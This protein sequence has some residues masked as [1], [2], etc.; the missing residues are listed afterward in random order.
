[1]KLYFLK[2]SRMARGFLA[3]IHSNWRRL[4][5]RRVLSQC[6]FDRDHNI[7]PPRALATADDEKNNSVQLDEQVNSVQP[8]LNTT[9][10]SCK[11]DLSDELNDA[12]SRNPE[13]NHAAP[14]RK[15]NKW[16]YYIKGRYHRFVSKFS[17]T[18]FKPSRWFCCCTCGKRGTHEFL[19]QK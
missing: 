10:A 16:I 2:R 17:K 14:L 1:M 7:L 9:L 8:D 15:S 11:E 13:S 18:K 19:M 4:N 6:S 3:R 5:L 12:S